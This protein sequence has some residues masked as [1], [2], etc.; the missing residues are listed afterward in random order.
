M[1]VS[2]IA[3]SASTRSSTPLSFA[4]VLLLVKMRGRPLA[5]V[6]DCDLDDLVGNDGDDARIG[7]ECLALLR[8]KPGAEAADRLAEGAFGLDPLLAA[9]PLDGCA[10]VDARRRE[11]RCSG[12][13]ASGRPCESSPPVAGVSS[14]EPRAHRECCPRPA[15]P[16]RTVSVPRPVDHWARAR[17]TLPVARI[18]PARSGRALPRASVPGSASGS[19]EATGGSVG[20]GFAARTGATAGRTIREAR[21]NRLIRRRIRVSASSGA[22]EEHAR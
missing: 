15:S 21:T 11:G 8:V 9:H 2:T 1:P 12:R 19:A 3:T 14:R 4:I 6:W 16:R 18:R 13:L 17:A 5:C 22:T 20:T 7:L 10:R